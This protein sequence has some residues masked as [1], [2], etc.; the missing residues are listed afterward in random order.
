MEFNQSLAALRADLPVWDA[1]GVRFE[2]GTEPLVYVSEDPKRGTGHLVAMDALPALTTEPNAGVPMQFVNIVDPRTFDILFAP[3]K[4]AE[5]FGGEEQRGSW[6]MISAMFPTNEFVGETAS[7]DDFAETGVSTANANWPQRENYIFETNITYGDLEVARGAVANYNVVINKQNAAAYIL[8]RQL[9]Y[10]YAFG[11]N[12]A[13]NYGSTNDPGLS[14]SL[15][16]ALKAYGGTAWSVSNVVKATPNEIFTDIQS[17]VG[18]V[19]SQGSG[20]ITTDSPMNFGIPASVGN[21]ITAANSFGVNVKGLVKDA[22]PNLKFITG[23][24]EYSAVSSTNPQGIAAG[25]LIQVV[26]PEVATQKTATP[27]YSDRMRTHRLIPATSSYRQKRS[28]GSWGT[29]IRQP[30]AIASMVGV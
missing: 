4:V 10:I 5:L 23:I 29:V 26:V 24:Q 15:T 11:V 27:A 1:R 22:Y 14:A 8:M 3:L 7:Y 18:Q 19:I 2:Y 17:T 21:A 16:P 30:F 12:G 6:E 20:N 9:N 13:Q 25:N 28:A